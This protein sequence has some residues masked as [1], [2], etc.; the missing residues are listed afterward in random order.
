[1]CSYTFYAII[2]LY[3]FLFQ[4]RLFLQDSELR[5][6]AGLRDRTPPIGGQDHASHAGHHA[7]KDPLPYKIIKMKNGK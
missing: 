1:M 6:T 5:D 7:L 2:A 3:C 4:V